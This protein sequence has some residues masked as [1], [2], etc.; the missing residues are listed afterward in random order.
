MTQ[1]SELFKTDET[2]KKK[3]EKSFED[4]KR[5]ST[6][7][8]NVILSNKEMKENFFYR[9]Y[10]M[11]YL[12]EMLWELKLFKLFLENREAFESLNTKLGNNLEGAFTYLRFIDS[13]NSQADED[14]V[15]IGQKEIFAQI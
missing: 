4:M 12:I 13:M 15:M 9:A 2:F 1:E 8:K 3:V 6:A 11:T 10:C 14:K 7:I 5:M